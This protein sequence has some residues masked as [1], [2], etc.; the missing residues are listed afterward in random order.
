MRSWEC[1]WMRNCYSLLIASEYIGDDLESLPPCKT[2]IAML[3]L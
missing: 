2:E 1:L 3:M